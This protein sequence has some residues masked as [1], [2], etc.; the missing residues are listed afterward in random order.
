MPKIVNETMKLFMIDNKL[1]IKS[2]CTCNKSV[3]EM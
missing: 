3:K 2:E 1:N